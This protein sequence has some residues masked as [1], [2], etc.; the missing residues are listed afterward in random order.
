[1]Y[2][3]CQQYIFFGFMLL[4][5]INAEWCICSNKCL[6]QVVVVKWFHGFRT[7]RGGSV[8]VGCGEA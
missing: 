1:M 3:N 8:H 6:R 5:S 2:Q 7:K 4:F